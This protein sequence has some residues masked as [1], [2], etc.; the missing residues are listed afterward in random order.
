MRKK[1]LHKE[2]EA[3]SLVQPTDQSN[4]APSDLEISQ[5][6]GETN[7]QIFKIPQAIIVKYQD[8]LIEVPVDEVLVNQAIKYWFKQHGKRL[9]QRLLPKQI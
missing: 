3:Q 9:V 2:R 1:K 5:K 8:R 4:Q 6:E 7:K